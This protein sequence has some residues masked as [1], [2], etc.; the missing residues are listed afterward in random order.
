MSL[1]YMKEKTMRF[2]VVEDEQD[3]CMAMVARVQDIRSVEKDEI[4][5]AFSSEDARKVIL[6]KKSIALYQI[7]E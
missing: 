2:L 3:V 1:A 4:L 5:F 7:F 6:E